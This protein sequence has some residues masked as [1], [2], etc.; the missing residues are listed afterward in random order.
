MKFTP[1][2]FPDVVM[3]E[4]EV[5]GDPRG[6]F[7]ESYHEDAFRK[8]GIRAHF[9]QD[10]HSRSS[11]GVLRALHFQTKPR[12]QAKLIRVVS[13][14]VLDVIVD[15][16]TASKTFGQHFTTILNA[17]NKKMLFIP[18]GFAH[19][20]LA[21]KDQTEF[22]YKVTDFYSPEHE[23]G[24]LWNDPSIDISWP[25]LDTEYILSEKDKKNPLLK[26]AFF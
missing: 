5:F 18:P 25:K 1:T 23:R 3:I 2:K 8:N 10:N 26:D 12:E 14:E 6:F 9:V 17:E 22:L 7:Y 13:G 4:P 16:R 20:F 15:V 21:L 11:K 19:G 24:I